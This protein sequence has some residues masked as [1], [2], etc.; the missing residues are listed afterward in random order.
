MASDTLTEVTR[1]SWFSR[2][3][4]A[5]KGV[6]VGLVLLAL[7]FVLLFWNEG[8]A[9]ERQKTLKEGGGEVISVAADSVDPVNE[10]KLIHITGMTV[11]NDLLVDDVFG[12]S[13][14]GL[15]L[16]RDVE[17]YQWEERSTSETKDKLGGG[18]ETVTTYTYEKKWSPAVVDSTR[19]KEPTDRQNPNVMLVEPEEFLAEP[20]TV[21][22]FTLPRSLVRK[23]VGYEPLALPSDAQTPETLEHRVTMR[24]ADG[25]YVG[26]SPA[27]PQ[28]GDA[29]VAFLVVPLTD[30]SVVAAQRGTSFVPYQAEAGG[31]IELLDTGTETAEAMIEAAQS[32]N[33]FFSWVLRLAGFIVMFMGLAMILKP[34]SVVADVVPFI[35]SIVGAGTGLVS[36]LSAAVLSLTTIAIAWVFYRPLIGFAILA[37]VVALIVAIVL[38]VRSSKPIQA[39]TA[40]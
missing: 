7:A 12:V 11:T 19:F 27:T 39:P 3:G 29:R 5:F 34:L 25:F 4:G 33:E 21:G 20:V 23:I 38:K 32:S 31:T 17:M 15:K 9:V 35:G 16:K 30:V 26:E 22:A 10:G 36:F 14:S 28:V 37:V 40:A 13:A 2:I 8:R 6:I 18:Q 1:Q 24:Q